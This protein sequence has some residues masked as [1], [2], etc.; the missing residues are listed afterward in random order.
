MNN[1]VLSSYFNYRYDPQR[2]NVVWNNDVNS[3]MNLI[4]SVTKNKVHIKIFHDCFDN[5]PNI[6]YC[7]FI[8][9][10]PDKN[11]TPNVTRWITYYNYL[12][13]INLPLEKIFMVDATDVEMLTNP[14]DYLQENVIYTGNEFDKKMNDS[15]L[16]KNKRIKYIKIPDYLN[17]IKKNADSKKTLINCGIC[18]GHYDIITNFLS[19]LTHYQTIYAKG[20]LKQSVDT[21]FYVYTLLKHFRKNIE[22]GSHINTR[23]RKKEY[24]KDVWWKH[25]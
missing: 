5:I 8:K 25:K 18:G 2:K 10:K 4:N 1:I 14:F 9:I 21:Q 15:F 12:T 17:I 24:I 6:N 23:F 22:Q 19:K 20:I 11:Y 3:V 7:E 13:N 16:I